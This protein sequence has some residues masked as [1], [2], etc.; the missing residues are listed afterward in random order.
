MKEGAPGSDCIT[1]ASLKIIVDDVVDPLTY[2]SQL[3]L[4]QG[5]FPNELKVAKIVSVF[6]SKEAAFF[7][8]Y[9]PIS[10]HTIYWKIFEK[11]IFNHLCHDLNQ[12][13]FITKIFQRLFELN[14][15]F[16]NIFDITF[17]LSK[18]FYNISFGENLS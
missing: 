17:F 14:I 8:N 3:S 10:L 5:Y 16:Q 11:V 9:R 4:I 1:A 6:K 2:L 13:Y 7:K 12:N 18:C 15:R